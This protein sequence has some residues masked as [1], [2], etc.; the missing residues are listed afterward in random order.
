M[1]EQPEPRAIVKTSAQERKVK[2]RAEETNPAGKFVKGYSYSTEEWDNSR[3]FK[4]LAYHNPVLA[5]KSGN[6]NKIILW[7]IVTEVS[8]HDHIMVK[9]ENSNRPQKVGFDRFLR[10]YDPNKPPV[11]EEP[12]PKM[13]DYVTKTFHNRR[14]PKKTGASTKTA[15]PKNKPAGARKVPKHSRKTE[16]PT[17]KSARHSIPL[18]SPVPVKSV[19]AKGKKMFEW[20][21][22]TGIEGNKLTVDIPY[23]NG[24]VSKM[25]VTKKD[26]SGMFDDAMIVLKNEGKHYM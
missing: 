26:L 9:W 18:G 10:E 17:L 1:S 24:T 14:P 16:Q 4:N 19:N 23:K 12:P 21:R 13:A 11:D 7:T 5:A 6:S 8:G 20:G 15:P 25:E 22:V 3:N 2:W